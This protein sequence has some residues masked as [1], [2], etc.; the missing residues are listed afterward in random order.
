MTK[1]RLNLTIDEDLV[2]KAREYGINIS[3]FLEI[4]LREYIAMLELSQSSYSKSSSNNPINESNAYIHH[5]SSHHSQNLKTNKGIMAGAS[6][7]GVMTLPLRG[8]GRRFKS[9]LAHF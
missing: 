9:G 7:L 6:G 1:K 4:K 2:N 5:T 3:S 8:R